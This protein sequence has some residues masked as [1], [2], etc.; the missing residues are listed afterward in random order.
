EE[1][2]EA[3]SV[4]YDDLGQLIDAGGPAVLQLNGNAFLLL[5]G[6]RRGKVRVIAPTGRSVTLDR[7]PLLA[8]LRSPLDAEA[9]P[10]INALLD[11]VGVPPRRQKRAVEAFLGGFLADRSIA[12]GWILRAGPHSPFDTVLRRAGVPSRLAALLAVHGLQYGLWIVAW[13]LLGRAALGGTLAPGWMAAWCLLLMTLVPL[14][15]ATAWWI[16]DLGIR[17]GTRLKQR[18]LHG[19]LASEHD[20][21]RHEGAGGALGRVLESEAVE[22]LVLGGGLAALTAALELPFAL[23]VLSRGAAPLAHVGGA[24]AFIVGLAVFG[25]AFYRTVGSWTD[26]RLAITHELVEKMI[27]HQTRLA[28]EPRTSHHSGEAVGLE[29]YLERLEA[30]DRRVTTLTLVPRIWL[31]LALAALVPSLTIGASPAALAVSV[32]GV[33][34]TFASFGTLTA[35]LSSLATAAVSWQRVEPLFRAGRRPPEVGLPSLGA[36]LDARQTTDPDDA[37]DPSEEPVSLVRTSGLGFAYPSRDRPVLEGVDLDIHLGDRVLVEGPSGGGKSTLAA[38]L[39]GMRE[40]SRGLVTLYGMD[41]RSVGHAAWRRRLVMV[42]QFHENHVLTETFAFN[43][44]MGRGWPPWP[45]DLEL[46]RQVC[47]ELGLGELLQRMPS[48][49][50]QMVGDTGWQLSHGERSRLFLAR[51]LLQD[52]DLIL[53]DESFAALD[54]ENLERAMVCALKRGRTVMVI[55][56]P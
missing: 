42:P 41:R 55:A 56:H 47:V 51:A 38:L 49:L 48:G 12:I 14:R 15:M 21:V 2:V 28:Q 11:E 17:V 1:E 10:K 44:L 6:R 7:S 43:L 27:G 19:A 31:V 13:W 33:L 46:A 26:G 16:G 45:E 29:R 54:P 40:P 35:G 25:A 18:L 22:T 23:W 4:R 34:L 52:A 5:A 32:G 36:V 30:L 39:A 20:T 3:V 53:L 24:V 8:L 37:P 50:M 9:R